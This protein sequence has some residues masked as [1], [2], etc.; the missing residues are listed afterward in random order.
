MVAYDGGLKEIGSGAWAWMQP[1]GSWGLNNAGLIADGEA[2]LLVDTLFDLAHTQRMLD[3][4]RD[5][6]PAANAIG[7]VVNTHANGDHCW[8]NQLVKGADIVASQKAADEMLE[9]PPKRVAMLGKAARTLRALGPLGRGL[10]KV[11][12]AKVR[13]LVDA[14]PFVE[15][16]F[17]AF[18]FD[19][20]TLVPPT[21]TFDGET[22]LKVGDREVVLWEVGPAHTDGDVLAWLPDEKVIYTGDILFIEA[23]PIIWAGPVQNWVDAI[24]RIL[25][26]EA[27]VVV[28][29]HGPLASVEQVTRLRDYLAAIYQET[30]RCFDE[31]QSVEDATWAVKL[32]G[33]STWGEAERVAVNVDTIYRELSGDT[34]VPDPVDLFARMGRMWSRRQAS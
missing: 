33:F 18:A 32:E 24:D 12:P 34:S 3:A 7:T 26:L 25:A 4:M 23:H 2:S 22:T 1:D 29:G 10:G 31:G 14:G 6:V 28:P 27:Q 11:G 9:L 8:G 15:H 16:A 19:D 30:K 21:T 17:G 20:I 13:D 5:A